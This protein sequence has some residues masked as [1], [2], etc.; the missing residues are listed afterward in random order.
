MRLWAYRGDIRGRSGARTRSLNAAVDVRRRRPLAADPA[1]RLVR[2]GLRARRVRGV[3]Q[4]R[5]AG[6]SGV[7]ATISANTSRRAAGGDR[8]P[9]SRRRRGARR[10]RSSRLE[11]GG[12]QLGVRRRRRRPRRRAGRA[13]AARRSRRA[14]TSGP[15]RRGRCVTTRSSS[16]SS[17]RGGVPGAGPSVE[18]VAAR[19]HALDLAARRSSAAPR[20][21]ARPAAPSAACMTADVSGS[22]YGESLAHTML[23]GGQSVNRAIMSAGSHQ[24][25]SMQQVRVVGQHAPQ[26]REVGDRGVGEDQP[27][28]G[29]LARQPDG[30]APERRDPAAGVDE[31][32]HAPARAP[33]AT[34]SRTAGSESVNCSARGCSLIPRAPASRQRRASATAPGRAGRRGSTRRAGRPSRP[35]RPSRES[36]AG[37]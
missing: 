12:E 19:E 28:V 21:R 37:G 22:P 20:R 9:S 36:L 6:T 31:H 15:S 32:R 16:G 7:R 5:A 14:R 1:L 13:R 10:N 24:A 8:A 11:H 27:G 3:G 2:L 4:R 18:R 26:P 33:S 34:S 25:V 30:V 23:P 35:P 17:G 29:E